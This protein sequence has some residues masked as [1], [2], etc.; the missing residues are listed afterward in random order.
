MM[1]WKTINA[2]NYKD[3]SGKIPEITEGLFIL[4]YSAGHLI[5][6]GDFYVYMAK[7]VGSSQQ[8]GAF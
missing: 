8:Q 5:N 7:D 3:C 2:D 1:G 4:F 6:V